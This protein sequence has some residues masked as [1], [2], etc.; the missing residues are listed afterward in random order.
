M[1]LG[2]WPRDLAKG[3][4]LG[5]RVERL[6][7]LIRLRFG[8]LPSYLSDGNEELMWFITA[9]NPLTTA[10]REGFAYWQCQESGERILQGL[11]KGVYKDHHVCFSFFF[12]KGWWFENWAEDSGV[13]SFWV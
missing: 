3:V 13:A 10:L 11:S 8:R 6:G 9:L 12:N 7:L 1:R 4:R 5:V 2:L